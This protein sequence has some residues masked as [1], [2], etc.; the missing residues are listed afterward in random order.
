MLHFLAKEKIHFSLSAYS[1]SKNETG[2]FSNNGG[3]KNSEI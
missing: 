3:H 1:K 2:R